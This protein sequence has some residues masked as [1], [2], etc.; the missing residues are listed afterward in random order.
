MSGWGLYELNVCLG[1]WPGAMIVGWFGDCSP[2]HRGRPTGTESVISGRT[3][4]NSGLPTLSSS[5]GSSPLPLG[6]GQG[7]G[8]FWLPGVNMPVYDTSGI[9]SRAAT[10]RWP[11]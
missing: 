6:E 9:A 2:R 10:R 1:R 11:T 7:E 3:Y 5:W 4:D 8:A